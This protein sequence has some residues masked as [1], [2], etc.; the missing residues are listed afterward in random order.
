[1]LARESAQVVGLLGLFVLGDVEP[2]AEADT[3]ELGQHIAVMNLLLPF[4]LPQY[5]DGKAA[6][7]RQAAG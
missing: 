3:G 1:L 2:G 6:T 4:A 5:S 7:L